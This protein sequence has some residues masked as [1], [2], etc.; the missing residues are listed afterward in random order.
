[1]NKKDISQ[2]EVDFD[3]LLALVQAGK[4]AEAISII[5]AIPNSIEVS[6][7]FNELS[8]RTYCELKDVSSMVALAN[9]GTQFALL[10]SAT[11]DNSD[12]AEKLRTS[13]KI[14]A[15]NTAANC[16]PGWGDAGIDI[17]K[18]HLRAGLKL[19]VLSRDLVLELNLGHKQRGTAHWL[20]GAL[21]LAMGQCS[22]AL[23]AF[24]HA[25]GEVP[26]LVAIR[27]LVLMAEGYAAL[28]LKAQPESRLAGDHELARIL[29]LL[30]NRG[31]K[32]AKFFANQLITAGTDADPNGSVGQP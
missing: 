31:T 5:E 8:K 26:K 9:A 4:V 23:A 1:M 32:D 2:S 25:K 18:D 3:F 12:D 22:E 19:A 21:E 17:N 10:R 6:A 7:A 14:L 16:W 30:D 24:Q 20:I 28:A 13:A 29:L 11:S 15:F 27:I